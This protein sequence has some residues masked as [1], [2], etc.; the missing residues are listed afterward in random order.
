MP[1][2]SLKLGLLAQYVLDRR[3][4]LEMCLLS[5]LHTGASASLESH[6]FGMFF[7]RGFRVCLNTDDRLM[8]DTTMTRETTLATEIFDLSLSE[9][10]KLSINAMKSAFAPYDDRIRMIFQTIKPGFA[11][12]RAGLQTGS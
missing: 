10:E 11:A 1:D 5:N 7:R 6:P 4:P 9:L 12:V 3:V 8:S 2:G